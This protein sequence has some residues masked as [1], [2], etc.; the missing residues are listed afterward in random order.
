MS[1]L[2]KLEESYVIWLENHNHNVEAKIYST[3]EDRFF[4]DYSYLPII[5]GSVPHGDSVK[6]CEDIKRARYWIKLMAKSL[7]N[8]AQL[9]AQIPITI[10]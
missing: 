4:I 9:S 10:K 5:S 3:P 1:S 6:Y 8:A 2:Y 7:E